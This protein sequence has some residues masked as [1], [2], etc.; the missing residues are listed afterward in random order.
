MASDAT[1][2]GIATGSSITVT[3]DSIKRMN[4]DEDSSI[5]SSNNNTQKSVLRHLQGFGKT[6]DGKSDTQAPLDYQ[7]MDRRN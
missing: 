5:G 4:D 6:R 3:T 7:T 1:S 2:F